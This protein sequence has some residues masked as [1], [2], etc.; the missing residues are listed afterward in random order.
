MSRAANEAFDAIDAA[1]KEARR[2]RTVLKRRADTQIRSLKER[3]L[4][5]ATALAWFNNHRLT[6]SSLLDS[7]V[8]NNVDTLY[9]SV[10]QASD[11]AAARKTY[12]TCLKSILQELSEIRA[13][14]VDVLG[15]Q[16][17]IHTKDDLP[18]FP[19]L[20]SD[21]RM[22]A[23]LSNRWKECRL[24]IS[25]NAP[26]AAT[27][28]MGGLLEALLLARINNESD[29]E[30]VFKAKTVPIDSRTGKAIQ[31]KDWTL[32][33]YIDVAHE[34]G[35]ISQSV[36]DVGEVLRDYRNYVHPYKQ[37]SHNV[38]LSQGDA[39]L[40]WEIT[41]SISRQLLSIGHRP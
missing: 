37:L 16:A 31:L 10:L 3:S 1:I 18:D 30:K 39:T 8:L 19:Y 41:K 35:W 14:V 22:Q 9:K 26:L 23:I 7:A 25:V 20:I 32:R 5:K 12:D 17:T 40:F 38:E 21:A 6:V 36:K 13:C 15:H 27:V 2:L 28:M 34:L 33:N 24:C 29:K 4:S 11:H